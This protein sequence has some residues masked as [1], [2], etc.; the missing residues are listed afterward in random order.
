MFKILK[1]L[2]KVVKWLTASKTS[3]HFA[4]NGVASSQSSWGAGVEQ[5]GQGRAGRLEGRYWKKPC[6]LLTQPWHYLPENQC[7]SG[8]RAPSAGLGTHAHTVEN[9]ILISN[10]SYI[11]FGFFQENKWPGC[12]RFHVFTFAHLKLTCPK[13]L[14]WAVKQH[15][16]LEVFKEPLEWCILLDLFV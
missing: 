15:S 6:L 10:Q 13:P 3:L 7:Q 11:Y 16:G 2:F 14:L 8:I 12:A 4:G 9:W 5:L 1:R